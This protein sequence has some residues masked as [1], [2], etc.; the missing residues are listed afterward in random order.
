MNYDKL[1]DALEPDFQKFGFSTERVVVPKEKVQASPHKLEGERINLVARRDVGREAVSV[2][3]HMDVVPVEGDWKYDPFKGTIEGDTFYGRGAVDN[4][5]SIASLMGALKVIHE[6][7]LEPN[8]NIHCVLC[9][10]EELG[11]TAYPGVQHL[12][13][14]G[15]VKGHVVCL[16][17]GS[18]EP[19]ILQ[20]CEGSMDVTINGIGKSCHSGSN[21]QGV[22]ALEQMIPIM[23]ELMSLK[24]KVEARESE[25]PAFPLPGAPSMQLTPM[26]NLSMIRG[27]TKSNIVPG[28]CRLIINRRYIPEEKPDEVIREIEEAVKRGRSDSGLIDLKLDVMKGYPPFVLDV[29]S[30]YM[31]RFRK[32]K[33]AVHG[34]DMFITG[35]MG[36]S[37]DMGCVSETLKTDKFVCFG[38]GRVDNDTAHGANERVDIA[39]LLSMTKE[40]VHYL[41][42]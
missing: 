31:E 39:D 21:F 30:P 15:Y 20:S 7:S 22:N 9:T 23:N 8:F 1:V 27:G 41:A 14:N 10:D 36:G 19:A 16:D 3:A 18:Q 5:G 26:F 24:N 12:A 32:T 38:P 34:Y 33:L 4:K 40:L 17:L 37:T 29:E 2:Y 6:L 28:E 35:G 25:Y 11:G 42:F 13:L